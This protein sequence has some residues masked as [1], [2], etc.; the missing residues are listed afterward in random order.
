MRAAIVDGYVDEPSTLGV[1]PYISPYP[2]LLAGAVRDAGHDWLYLTADELRA[3]GLVS[4]SPTLPAPGARER[5]LKKARILSECDVL[6]LSGG[7][8]V[9]GKYLRGLPLS[10]R[11]MGEIA[12]AFRGAKLLGGPL[13]RFSPWAL[14]GVW[15]LFDF[16]ARKD[17]EAA[18]YE[19][20]RV[21]RWRD[22]ERSAEE[23]ERWLRMGAALVREHPDFPRPLMVELLLYRGCVRYRSGGCSFCTDALYGRPRFRTPEDVAAEVS[24]LHEAGAVGFRLGGASCIFSYLAEGV[25]TTEAPRPSLEA[26]A[27]LLRGIRAAAPGLEVLH[28]DNANPAVIASHPEESRAIL[29]EL[30]S[31]CTGGNVLSLGLESADPAV[32]EANNLN[33]TPEQTLEAVRMINAAGAAMSPTGLPA[34]LPGLNFLCGLEAETSR[35]YELNLDFLRRLAGEGVLLRRINIRQVAPVRRRF[36]P[37]RHRGA[38]LR[39]KERVRREIDR[40]MLARI[41]PF[42]TVLRDV[43]PEVIIGRLVFGRQSGT[44]PLLVGIPKGAGS[45]EALMSGQCLNIVVVD[46][47]ERSVTGLPTPLK[48]NSLPLSALAAIRGIGR[49]RAARIVRRRPFKNSSEVSAALD[50]PRPLRPLMELISCER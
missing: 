48:V 42:G 50:D 13:A 39:F 32:M 14:E 36:P 47:G 43:F 22:R 4:G 34:L 23:E 16:V 20:L 7:A 3:A 18:L 5:A 44:Y 15:G 40:P 9:P 41:A 35:T 6:A 46:H 49:M 29:G 19:Y 38:F 1:P 45:E 27:R 37:L 8:S 24:A 11:E 2:R 31:Y 33:A 17:A 26:V 30:V 12:R 21:G 25:G 28:T 10:V